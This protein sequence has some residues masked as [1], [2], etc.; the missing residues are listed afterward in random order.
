MLIFLAMLASTPPRP[1]GLD[2][3]TVQSVN[4]IQ[5]C[6]DNK[7]GGMA[8]DDAIAHGV[9][10]TVGSTTN[11]FGMRRT[12]PLTF[13]IIDAGD[14]RHIS[15]L[16]RHPLSAKAAAMNLRQFGR[17]CFPYEL[18]ASGLATPDVGEK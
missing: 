13:E 3:Q 2:V 12:G 1:T 14:V 9:A 4:A 6:I 17:K 7:A 16:Y 11:I 10:I 5:Q 15:V 8:E 18:S